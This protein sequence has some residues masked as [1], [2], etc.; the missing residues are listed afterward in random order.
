MV[1]LGR[2]WPVLLMA[3]MRYS[4]FTLRGWFLR[5]IS[6]ALAVAASVQSPSGSFLLWTTKAASLPPSMGAFQSRKIQSGPCWPASRVRD[7]PGRDALT[8]CR[9]APQPRN[10]NWASLPPVVFSAQRSCLL[11]S[12]TKAS[13]AHPQARRIA[14]WCH[15]L[16]V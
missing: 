11:M 9:L 6:L 12:L 13:N 2:P 14:W 3:T 5:V 15:P 1:L 10:F 16:H 8:R 7:W 4:S